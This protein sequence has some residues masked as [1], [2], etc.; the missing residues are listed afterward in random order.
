VRKHLGNDPVSVAF[1]AACTGHHIPLWYSS[2]LMVMRA[3][4]KRL[5]TE[6]TRFKMLGVRHHHCPPATTIAARNPF[7]TLLSATRSLTQCAASAVQAASSSDRASPGCC[8]RPWPIALPLAHRASVAASGRL[9]RAGLSIS[10]A[11]SDSEMMV[12]FKCPYCR[13]EYEMATARLSFQLRSYAKC[14]VCYQTMYSWNSRNVPMFKFVNA[15]KGE[16]SD[17]Q[18]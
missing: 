3:K 6:K 9:G 12:F 16:T 11:V 4:L 2:A 18:P 10:A 14:Q 15:S 1:I 8:Q 17:I 13:T 7:R 5:V